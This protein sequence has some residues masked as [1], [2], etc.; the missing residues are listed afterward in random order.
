MNT[1]LPSRADYKLW[2]SIEQGTRLTER[3]VNG[4]HLLGPLEKIE[5]L[6]TE[7]EIA[8]KEG[9]NPNQVFPVPCHQNKTLFFSTIE[10]LLGA[11]HW[12]FLIPALQKLVEAKWSAANVVPCQFKYFAQISGQEESPS[13][14]RWKTIHHHLLP[15]ESDWLHFALLHRA[16]AFS[17]RYL[18]LVQLLVKAG[19]PL[20]TENPEMY[21]LHVALANKIDLNVITWLLDHGGMSSHPQALS[22]FKILLEINWNDQYPEQVAALTTNLHTR[23][24]RGQ[25]NHQTPEVNLNV[26]LLRR[27]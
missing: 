9:G 2:S 17:Q 8:L 26:G 19:A 27:L 20:L 21:P 3:H 7:I 11:C 5:H 1:S 18:E 14:L 15:L 25:I 24:E 22:K 4:K 6:L 16:N 13:P 10:L 12:D 23:A